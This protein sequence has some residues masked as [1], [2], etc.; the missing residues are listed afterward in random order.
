MRI[1]IDARYLTREYSG[2]GNHSEHLVR[3]L[4]ALDPDNQYTIFVH[5]SYD[6]ELD[7]P[8]NSEIIHVPGRPVSLYS[9]FQ[10]RGLIR[11]CRA[12][13]LHSLFPILPLRLKIPAIITIHDL[14]PLVMREFSSRRIYPLRKAYE[15]F[16]RF[17][18]PYAVRRARYIIAVS[19]TTRRELAALI[20][21]SRSNTIVIYPG[22]DPAVLEPVDEMTANQILTKMNLP[23]RYILYLGSTRPNKN[24][25][26]MI[27]AFWRLCARRKD[28]ADMHLV[29]VLNEDRFFEDV[30]PLLERRRVRDQVRVFGQVSE[31]EK[32]CLYERASALL[33][34]TKYEG[35]GMPLIEAQ[36]AGTPVLIADHGALPEVANGSA[37]VTQPD[38][39]VTIS[40]DLYQ[41][42]TDTELRAKLIARGRENVN[43]FDWDQTAQA[44]LDMYHHLF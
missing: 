13:L 16:Y 8:D 6:R 11:E 7:L 10:M 34:V 24:L 36:A 12:D 41:I 35:F 23:D 25:P 31:L 28:M 19:H 29:L 42:L 9:L 17:V 4:T 26:N 2:I 3:R 38:S 14:Q 1:A 39:V 33:F 43:R 30:R 18:Y 37:L 27:R 40:D 21:E 20:P 32:R 5:Q 44:I 15:H 22:V